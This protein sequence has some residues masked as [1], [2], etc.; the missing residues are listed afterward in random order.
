MPPSHQPTSRPLPRVP[1]DSS[2]GDAE[3]HVLE[4][5]HAEE[6]AAL[7]KRLEM[8]EKL[9]LDRESKLEGLLK[10]VQSGEVSLKDTSEKPVSGEINK[11]AT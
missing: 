2:F 8:L 9:A 7:E 11:I 4:K 5:A 3:R 1:G 10:L 6:R